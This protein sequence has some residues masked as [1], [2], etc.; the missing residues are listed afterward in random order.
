[1]YFDDNR[2]VNKI[3]Y[4]SENN[5]FFLKGIIVA[6]VTFDAILMKTFFIS[7]EL[8]TERVII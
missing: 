2:N 1:M 7:L 4:F 3:L 8:S 5:Q 6:L